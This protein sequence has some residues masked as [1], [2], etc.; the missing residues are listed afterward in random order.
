[1]SEVDK[2][3]MCKSVPGNGVGE[4]LSVKCDRLVRE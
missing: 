1:M 2:N 4:F 3:K